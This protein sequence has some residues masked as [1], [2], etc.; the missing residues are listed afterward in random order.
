MGGIMDFRLRRQSLLE[1]AKHTEEK[2]S[3]VR[4]T[5]AQGLMR[6]VAALYREMAEEL[7][8]SG[9]FERR[10]LPLDFADLAGGDRSI[11]AGDGAWPYLLYIWKKEA[12]SKCC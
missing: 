11:S 7:E 1:R 6:A 3:R 12:A 9:L 4:N 10:F 2:A 8:D 5:Q